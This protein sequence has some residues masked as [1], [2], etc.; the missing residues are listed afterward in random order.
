MLVWCHFMWKAEMRE[1][2]IVGKAAQKFI[3]ACLL[4][5]SEWVLSLFS[6][7]EMSAGLQRKWSG[8]WR[9]QRIGSISVVPGTALLTGSSWPVQT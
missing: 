7:D 5:G 1:D 4:T 8:L 6:A 9:A 3:Q 2:S